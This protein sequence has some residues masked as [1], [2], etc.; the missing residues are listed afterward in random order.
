MKKIRLLWVIC[1]L[2][3]TLSGCSTPEKSDKQIIR[4]AYFPNITH[5]QALLG[6][7]KKSFEEAFGD[8]VE[9]QWKQ[10]NAGPA[11]IEA[12]FASEVDMGYIGPVPAINGYTKSN[13]ELQILAGASNGGAVLVTRNDL[14]ISDIKELSG[15]KIAIP[16]YGNT[17]DLTLRALLTE[18]GLKSTTEGGTVEI[19]QV[20]NPDIKISLDRKQIDAAFVPEPW[21]ARLEV[22]I[23]ANVALN[24]EKIYSNG[25]YSVAVVIGRT[26]FIEKNPELV[27]KFLQVHLDLTEELNNNKAEAAKLVNAKLNELTGKQLEEKTLSLA[28]ERIDFNVD[29]IRESVNQFKD[30]SFALG[31]I[32]EDVNTGNLFNF[33]VMNDLLIEKEL[34]PIK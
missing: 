5:S 27:K 10:F 8:K 17:Q 31:F 15:L 28:F 34:N 29:P 6:Q 3:A 11:E 30:S 32:K 1:L 23:G 14:V 33:K 13:G 4:I 7:S 12:F 21:G 22:E 26:S 2:M 24:A 20:E 9:I 18:N 19:L 16:Q 25:E